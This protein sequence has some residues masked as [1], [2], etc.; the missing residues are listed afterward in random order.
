MRSKTSRLGAKA[1]ALCGATFALQSDR[2]R[3]AN[4]TQG[5]Q[6]LWLHN[7]H[8][9]SPPLQG[10][11]S[12]QGNRPLSLQQLSRRFATPPPKKSYE[13]RRRKVRKSGPCQ[14]LSL[15]FP[16]SPAP[17][18]ALRK[19]LSVRVLPPFLST[20][21]VGF[22]RQRA[23]APPPTTKRRE[24]ARGRKWM[25]EL[26]SVVLHY[27]NQLGPFFEFASK[28]QKCLF[29]VKGVISASLAGGRVC[30][31]YPGILYTLVL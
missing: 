11:K 24:W 9:A 20:L 31:V 21:G 15:L 28:L 3:G 16:L 1:D 13:E 4:M 2:E 25:F 23:A 30:T 14:F 22:I 18:R 17:P 26:K 29:F 27:G 19:R 12:K 5:K 8:S 10:M 7:I 6:Q